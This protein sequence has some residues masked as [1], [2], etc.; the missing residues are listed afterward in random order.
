MVK[1]QVSCTP[2][3]RLEFAAAARV[4]TSLVD[5]LSDKVDEG[6]LASHDQDLNL[7]LAPRVVT[8]CTSRQQQSLACEGVPLVS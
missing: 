7:K 6:I 3:T 1:L 8:Q 4:T 5:D 2:Q